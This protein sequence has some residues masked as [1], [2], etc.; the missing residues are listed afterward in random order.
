ME[1][2]TVKRVTGMNPLLQAMS[3]IS[4]MGMSPF[5]GSP[6]DS[7]DAAVPVQDEPKQSHF[8]QPVDNNPLPGPNPRVNSGVTNIPIIDNVLHN[9]ATQLSFD[10][11]SS[12]SRL[13]SMSDDPFLKTGWIYTRV[14]Q[15]ATFICDGRVLLDTPSRQSRILSI[16]PI[17]VPAVETVK[18]VVKGSNL[19]GPFS[20][21][22]CAIEGKYLVQ[23]SCYCLVEGT[24]AASE[25]DGIQ[26][27][28]FNCSTPNV[29]G[30]GFIEV[31][32]L[33]KDEKQTCSTKRLGST[34]IP[35][36]GS[37]RAA[38]RQHQ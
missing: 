37:T 26:S 36:A 9:A 15:R 34:C 6:S 7:A 14:Q 11:S 19:S 1:E 23:E 3:E 8:Y 38:H 28:S 27:L 30:R 10:M 21:L 20:R 33:V 24:N 18:L 17:A 35:Y 2:E 29:V 12:L 22:L 16:S 5:G 31:L 32:H 25:H 13:L 4:A